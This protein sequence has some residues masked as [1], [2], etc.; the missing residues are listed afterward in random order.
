MRWIVLRLIWHQDAFPKV[1]SADLL[2]FYIA[3][4]RT[5][6]KEPK[7]G[8]ASTN[9]PIYPSISGFIADQ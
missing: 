5:G 8:C 4:R 7:G 6:R 9:C 1:A 2:R 3:F